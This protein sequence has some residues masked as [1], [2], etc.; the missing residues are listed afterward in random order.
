M[1]AHA[2]SLS[3]EDQQAALAGGGTQTGR[4]AH[5]RPVGVQ[6]L[7]VEPGGTMGT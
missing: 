1:P 7:T 5:Y 6:I 2:Y 3:V 4:L